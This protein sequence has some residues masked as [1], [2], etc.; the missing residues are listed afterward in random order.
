MDVDKYYTNTNYRK[1]YLDG[2]NDN[3]NKTNINK[4]I[5]YE[6][7]LANEFATRASFNMEDHDVEKYNYNKG[8]S[9]YHYRIA[10]WLEELKNLRCNV[11][12]KKDYLKEDND[13]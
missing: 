7:K 8:E 1:G 4:T 12:S 10:C 3:E 2:V 9:K 13:E 11:V 6:K 5:E